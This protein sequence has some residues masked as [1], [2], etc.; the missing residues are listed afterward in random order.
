[1]QSYRKAR[2]VAALLMAS[3]VSACESGT[4]PVPAEVVG[5]YALVSVGGAALP[6]RLG[7]PTAQ[8]ITAVRGDLILRDDGEYLQLI[9]TRY[10]DAEGAAQT[11]N[12]STRGDFRING[13]ELVLEEQ[14][15]P[16]RNGTIQQETVRYSITA[17]GVAVPLE[18]KK[19]LN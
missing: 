11:G 7:P 3:W 16:T 1:M 13:T 6:A 8:E 19:I 5:T 2:I 17:G 12:N 15:G 10:V 14:L 4:E 18:W 9:Q